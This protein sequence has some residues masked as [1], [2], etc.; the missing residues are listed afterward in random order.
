M[1][2]HSDG[3]VDA[4][5]DSEAGVILSLSCSSSRQ[6]TPTCTPAGE[7]PISKPRYRRLDDMGARVGH[8]FFRNADCR[9]FPVSRVVSGVIT[10][11]LSRAW[12]SPHVL[13]VAPAVSVPCLGLHPAGP[14]SACL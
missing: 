9:W 7:M 8:R 6:R 4:A 11:S 2:L 12:K 1:S 14:P 10:S 5:S 3:D 13:V